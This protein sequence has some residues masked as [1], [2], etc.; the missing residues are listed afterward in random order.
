[1]LQ[2]T[3]SLKRQLLF[4]GFADIQEAAALQHGAFAV[5]LAS[6]GFSCVTEL[7]THSVHACS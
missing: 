7:R 6:L 5:R 3:G 4:Q 1:M 2:D